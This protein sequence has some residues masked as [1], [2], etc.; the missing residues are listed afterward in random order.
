MIDIRRS[1]TNQICNS[2]VRHSRA[3]IVVA[4]QYW[5]CSW[6]GA[7][8]S[9]LF[10]SSLT[11]LWLLVRHKQPDT[12]G[13]RPKA[14]QTYMCAPEISSRQTQ[15]RVGQFEVLQLLLLESRAVYSPP[16]TEKSIDVDFIN[17][18]ISVNL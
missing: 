14:L 11:R 3:V 4:D 12:R 5:T 17:Q 10:I 18:C 9:Q 15:S 16:K 6:V 8:R 13:T 1:C 7:D 2:K